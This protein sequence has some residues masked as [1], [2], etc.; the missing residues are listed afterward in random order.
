MV[1]EVFGDRERGNGEDFFFAHQAHG[2]VAELIGVIDG[3]DSGAGGVERAGFSGSVDRDPIAGARGFVDRG[4]ELLLGILVRRDEL[5]VDGGVRAGFVNFDEVGAFLELFA[6]DGDEFGDVVGVGGVGQHA[7]LGI[8]ADGVFVAA[9]N[10][11][12][13]AGDAQARAGDEAVVDGVTDGGV[14]GAG[15]FG[16]HVA[17]GGETAHQ[18]VASS[19]GGDDGALRDGFLYGLQIFGAGMEEEV[20]VG[21]DEAGEEGGV[22]EV[23]DFGVRGPRN[24]CA[25]FFDEVAVDENFAG[26]SDAA[27]FDVEQAR[28]VEDEGTGRRRD[29][30]GLGVDGRSWGDEDRK[31][32]GCGGDGESANSSANFHGRRDVSTQRGKFGSVATLDLKTCLR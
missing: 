22:A 18:V 5:T 3:F 25:D 9:E 7:L 12:G 21:V 32:E 11:D 13:V 26:G 6:D 29:G 30:R 24:F 14:G 15:A 8:E 2:L 17:F 19:E 10:I 28:G 16:A 23:E 1:G 27:G 4:G 31:G 20:N